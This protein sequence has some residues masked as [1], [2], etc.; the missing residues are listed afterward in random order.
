MTENRKTDRPVDNSD[1]K[2]LL[3]TIDQ[4]Y[5][6]SCSVLN[7][8][9]QTSLRMSIAIEAQMLVLKLQAMNRRWKIHLPFKEACQVKFFDWSERMSEISREIAA[10]ASEDVQRRFEKFCPSKH[11]LLDL[12]A[13]IND[14]PESKEKPY[15]EETDIKKFIERQD[16][17]RT[18]IADRWKEYV[19]EVSD[20][21][22][23]ELASKGDADIVLSYDASYVQ[24]VCCRVLEHLSEIL[25]SLNQRLTNPI[26]RKDFSRLADRILIEGDYGGHHAYLKAMAKVNMWRNNTPYDRIE[27]E[28]DKQIEDTI[29]EIEKS[30][31]G[32]QFMQNV[33]IYKD[34]ESQKDSFGKFLFSERSEITKEDL[35]KLFELIFRIYHLRR[36]SEQDDQDEPEARS[37][38]TDAPAV[39][40]FGGMESGVQNPP[41]PVEFVQGLRSNDQAVAKFYELLR[42]AGPY[43]NRKKKN[44]AADTPEARY[45]GWKWIH[46]MDALVKLKLLVSDVEKLSYSNFIHS[47]FPDRSVASVSRALYRS[48]TSTYHS[49]VGDIVRFFQ[50]VKDILDKASRKAESTHSIK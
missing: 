34:F 50:P 45:G 18:Y 39:G 11:F 41:L 16:L 23:E 25:Y 21:T 40:S 14:K 12:Y 44:H 9:T 43:M 5:Q 35:G 1:V 13:M 49:T 31:F 17:M 46:L 48:D 20:R 37:G 27:A 30:K 29:A 28:R 32:G 24:L 22:V 42:K 19:T 36:V 10:S 47:V 4:L 6:V 7:D 38:R 8:H 26:S 33:K 2:S 3:E 15:Y